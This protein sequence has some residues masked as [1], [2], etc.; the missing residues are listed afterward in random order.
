MAPAPAPVAATAVPSLFHTHLADQ[1]DDT[2]G[3]KAVEV[4]AMLGESVVSVKHCMDPRGGKVTPATL[5][6][7]AVGA[8]CLLTSAVAFGMSV[9]TAAQN[10]SALDYWTTTLKKPAYSFRAAQV[11]TGVTVGAFAGA[12]LG[13]LGVTMGLARVRRERK[14]PYYRIGTAPGVEMPLDNAPAANFPMIAPRG[15]DFVFNLGAGMTGEMIVDGTSTSL[16]TLAAQ[17]QPSASVAGAVELPIPAKAKI[18]VTSGKTTFLVSAMAKPRAQPTTLFGGLESRAFTYAAGSLA[19]HLGIVAFL[20][21]IPVEDSMARL[22]LGQEEPIAMRSDTTEKEVAV[23][24][25]KELDGQNDAAASSHEAAKMKLEEG[26]AGNP[27]AKQADGH[28]QIKNTNLDPQIARQQ[29]IEEARTAGILGSSALMRGGFTAITG[30]SDISSGADGANV[31]GPLF[32]ADGEGRGNF[33]MG[34]KGWGAGGGCNVGPCGING[35]GRYGTINGGDRAGDGYGGPGGSGGL[36]RTHTTSV[37]KPKFGDPRAE[38]DLDKEIIKR[39]MKR[40]SNKI[41]YCYEKRLLA[42]SSLAGDLMVNFFINPDGSVKAA[43]AKGFDGE[44][45]GCVA[46]VVRD[47]HFPKNGGVMVNY[48]FTFHAAGK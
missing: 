29:A 4:A 7:F 34:R 6:M 28:Q 38:G 23:E 19:V 26:A 20:S 39:Y 43:S 10:K 44:V 15:D 11:S 14:S 2:S 35:T 24:E 8:A 21:T 40:A 32:G 47:I 22:E 33:G 5:G 42:D 25:R 41:S 13:L 27:T 36:G 3:A 17:A 12:G 18:R 31:Y 30:E 45:A 9:S 48:P 1:T 46:D 37:P 16:A